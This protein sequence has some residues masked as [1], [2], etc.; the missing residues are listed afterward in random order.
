MITPVILCGGSGTRLWP[1][2]RQSVPKQFVQLIGDKS[3]F[4]SAVQ[5]AADPGFA[6]PVIVTGDAFRFMVQEQLAAVGQQASAILIEPEARNTAPAVLLAALHLA[7]TAPDALM[8][9]LPSDQLI[10]DPASFC[11]AVAAAQGHA[12]AGAMISFGIEPTRPDTGFGYLELSDPAARNAAQPQPLRR[13]VEKPDAAAAEAMLAT[14]RYLWNA[15]IFLFSVAAIIQ[16]FRTHAPDILAAVSAA[17]AGAQDDLGFTRFDRSAWARSPGISVDYAIMEK[18]ANLAVMPY[19]GGWVDL[20]DWSRVWLESGPDSAGNVC[21]AGATAIDCAGSL[22]RSEARGLHV[23]G[24]GLDNML[25]IATADAVLVAP[26]SA[27]GRVG[28][29]VARLRRDDVPQATASARELRPWGWFESIACGDRFQVKRILVKPGASMSLQSHQHRAE[30]WV[31][32]AG[33]ATVTV[34]ETV[35]E[36]EENQSV[37]IPAGAKHRLENKRETP[38][39]LVEVQTGAYL[40]EDDIVRYNDQYGRPTPE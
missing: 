4:Q 23:V 1:S 24:L 22:L 18:A 10:R 5:L 39:L 17:R 35:R 27:S 7:Q 32:V 37:Y 11:A 20:G 26:R 9:V 38:I 16:A 21:T 30:H 15:G 36:L 12:K 25:V 19:A 33:T 14:C 40:G 29:V 3:L 34:E 28:E 2:S 31:I 13:F 6:P 8:L